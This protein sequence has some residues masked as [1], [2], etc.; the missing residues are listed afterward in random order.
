MA[1]LGEGEGAGVA[2]VFNAAG[3]GAGTGEATGGDR[4]GD[5]DGVPPRIDRTIT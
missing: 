4:A 1:I 5:N 2:I 3:A